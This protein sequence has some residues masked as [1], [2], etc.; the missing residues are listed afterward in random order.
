VDGCT[1]NAKRFAAAAV[2]VSC[3]VAD[4]IAV[5]DVLAAVIV[6]VPAFVSAYVKLTVLDPVAIVSGP[7]GVNVAVP[8]EVLDNV[9]VRAAS[10]V[11]GLL[12]GSNRCTVIVP[13]ATPAVTV[14]GALV[15][16]S[17][18]AA[19]ALTVSCCVAEVIVPGDVL[20]AVIVGVPAFVSV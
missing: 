11:L 10:V 20:A 14:T 6:G 7:A 16:T 8:G 15:N 17:L 13:D 5:G 9:T 18:L 1:P 3:C 2:T 19:A 4:V 12:N